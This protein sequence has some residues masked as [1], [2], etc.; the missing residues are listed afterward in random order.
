MPFDPSNKIIQLCAEGMEAEGKGGIDAAKKIFLK[1]WE[2]STTDFEKFTAAHYLARNQ[3]DISE[4]LKW[5]T[6]SLRLAVLINEESMKTYFPSLHLNVGK[7]YEKLKEIEM[8]K[9]HYT[10]ASNFIKYLPDDGYG[11]MIR[12]GINEALKRVAPD[13]I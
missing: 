2:L 7:T 10:S 13:K 9:H 12:N 8:A 3:K 4:E 6:E 5:N 1:A 11:N